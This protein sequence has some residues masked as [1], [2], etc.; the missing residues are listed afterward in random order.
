[1]SDQER[2]E[3]DICSIGEFIT[4][5][6]ELQEKVDRENG[7][8][9][10]DSHKGLAFRGHEDESFE[11]IP[12]IGRKRR[13]PSD[14]SILDQERNLIEMARY[15]LPHIFKSDLAPIDLLSLLQHYGIPTRL[16]DV[17]SNPLVALYFATSNNE[18]DGE[19]IIF[20]YYDDNK[21]NYPVINAI[22]DSY[23]FAFCT[24][25]TLDLFYEDVITQSYFDEQ[26][27]Q[28]SYE[29][30]EEGGNW[31]K[32]CCNDLLFVNAQEQLERQ[33]LQQGFYILFPNKID[34]YGDN[35]YS[36]NKMILPIDKKHKQIIGRLIIKKGSKIDLRK[37]LKVLG[38]S[39]ATLFADNIDVVCRNIVEECRGYKV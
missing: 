28:L 32:S 9:Y 11:I 23:R 14:I 24:I 21:T 1:M 27:S 31:I 5:V 39:E 20:E 33:K 38:I 13:S 26:R 12:A 15:K 10:S 3:K 19:V 29:S 25:S 8:I 4:T 35:G 18:K 2:I 36:F 17:T 7:S 34:K 16:L 22:A 37:K 30:K 6:L